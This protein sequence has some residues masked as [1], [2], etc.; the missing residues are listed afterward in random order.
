M[1]Y[2]LL[3]GN[4]NFSRCPVTVSGKPRHWPWALPETQEAS[5]PRGLCICSSLCLK[6]LCPRLFTRLPFKFRVLSKQWGYLMLGLSLNP[7]PDTSRPLPQQSSPPDV[8]QI[9][10]APLCH[11]SVYW[12]L[13]EGRAAGT[14]CSSPRA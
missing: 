3:I 5:S 9:W 13:L 12:K 10:W 11:P 2:S 4:K 6:V 1:H 7:H 14:H 8:L